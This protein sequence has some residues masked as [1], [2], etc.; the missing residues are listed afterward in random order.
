MA[1]PA[2]LHDLNAAAGNEPA[3]AERILRWTRAAGL[4]PRGVRSRPIEWEPVHLARF[5]VACVSLQPI[6]SPYLIESF[7]RCVYWASPG[8]PPD[9]QHPR[10]GD[11]CFEHIFV[12]MIEGLARGMEAVE[13]GVTLEANI[14]AAPLPA[15]ISFTLYPIRIDLTWLAQDG[16]QERVD[17]YAPPR[18]SAQP[19]R[20]ES[21]IQHTAVMPSSLLVHAAQAWMEM[22]RH[23]RAALPDLTATSTKNAAPGRA[24]LRESLEPEGNRGCSMS[25]HHGQYARNITN[26]S[27]GSIPKTFFEEIRHGTQRRRLDPAS[28]HVA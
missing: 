23:R 1:I 17:Q 7:A 5:V 15:F 26:A 19:P 9:D 27:S 8:A 3:T 11:G 13:R 20:R 18:G 4:I 28:P 2:T 16:R 21:A 14:N 24:A 12:Q 10:E 25:E 6:D 22:S